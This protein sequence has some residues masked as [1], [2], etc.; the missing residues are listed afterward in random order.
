MTKSRKADTN[1]GVVVREV[2]KADLDSV[3]VLM[4]EGDDFHARLLPSHF[5]IVKQGRAKADL[6]C[7]PG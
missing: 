1:E 7:M 5:R 6:C 4:K 3:A 2:R